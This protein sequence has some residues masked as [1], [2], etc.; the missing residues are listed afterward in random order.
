[1]FGIDMPIF[2]LKSR[3]IF[4]KASEILTEEPS[5]RRITLWRDQI[6]DTSWGMEPAEQL[7]PVRMTDTENSQ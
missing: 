5:L 4:L 6:V 3:K 7:P 1:M 2:R